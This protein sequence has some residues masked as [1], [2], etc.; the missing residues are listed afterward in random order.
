MPKASISMMSIH[1]KTLKGRQVIYAQ[2]LAK[3]LFLLLT[4]ILHDAQD[5]IL[6]KKICKL[7]ICPSIDENL[8]LN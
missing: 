4:W 1:I 6:L 2:I 3:S 8:N 7:G 5:R